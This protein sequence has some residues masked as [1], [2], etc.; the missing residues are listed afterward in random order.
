[1]TE[2]AV[3]RGPEAK[4]GQRSLR[5]ALRLGY[6]L[7][8]AHEFDVVAPGGRCVG[9]L[10]RLRSERN[11]EYPDESVVR[12]QRLISWPPPVDDPVRGGRIRRPAPGH[13]PT[14]APG[15][16]DA[17]SSPGKRPASAPAEATTRLI[18]FS[19]SLLLVLAGRGGG[20]FGVEKRSLEGCGRELGEVDER[21][22][23]DVAELACAPVKQLHGSK[24]AAVE[25]L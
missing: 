6:E 10:E 16:T 4:E 20:R 5:E 25:R 11:V 2:N 13:R 15:M 18:D 23:V 21:R 7:S 8:R 14:S 17:R 1:M 12:S 24:Q 22:F 9:T 19:E 3:E